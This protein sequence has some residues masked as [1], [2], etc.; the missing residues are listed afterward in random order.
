M[1]N[2]FK[3]TPV[4]FV[5]MSS[6]MARA[7]PVSMPVGSGNMVRNKRL[8]GNVEQVLRKRG[9]M[10]SQA[11]IDALYEEK[12][13]LPGINTLAMVLRRHKE[14]A[15]VDEVKCVGYEG[16]YSVKVWYLRKAFE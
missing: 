6:T 7:P 2:Q 13:S 15:E 9:P 16:T 14:F 11:I 1:E 10:T 3:L 8:K 5:D 4:R 12:K